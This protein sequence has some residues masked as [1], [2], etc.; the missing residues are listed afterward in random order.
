MRKIGVY[1]ALAGAVVLLSTP[2]ATA[3]EITLK[4]GT[5]SNDKTSMGRAIAN[6]LM[7]KIKEYSNGRMEIASHWMGS[8]CGEQICGEQAK[9]G[10]IDIATS[11]TANFG[12]FGISYAS[13][14]QANGSSLRS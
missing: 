10:L 12:N 4:L 8:I 9:Q 1:A 13:A 11:S 6:V 14:D 3:A 5:V 2:Q 7:P